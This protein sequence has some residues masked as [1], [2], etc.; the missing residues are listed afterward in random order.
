MNRSLG[1]K[2]SEV[3]SSHNR[4]LLQASEEVQ[5]FRERGLQDL[6]D[7]ELASS[8][9]LVSRLNQMYTAYVKQEW[10]SATLL[11]MKQVII[12]SS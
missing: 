5:W 2:Y 8:N 10:A 9:A 4:L 3:C 12:Y 6:V 7:Q 1:K 11:Q